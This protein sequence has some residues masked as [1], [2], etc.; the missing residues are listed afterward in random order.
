MGTASQHGPP[1]PYESVIMSDADV[2]LRSGAP[3]DPPPPRFEITVSDP[4][5]QGEGVNAF[6][7]YR[8]RTK[9]TMPHYHSTTL[10]VIR[11]Y[12][13][14]AFL[15]QRLFEQNRG[16]II[17]PIPEKNVVQK[18]QHTAGF[19]AKRRAALEK[20]I[21]RVGSHPAL[22]ESDDLRAF[23]EDNDGAWQIVLARANA[24]HGGGA[25]KTLAGAVAMMRELGSS[26]LALIG[27]S[28][29]RGED[30]EESPDYLK[31]REYIYQLE[32]H[33]SDVQKQASRLIRKQEALAA[34]LHDFGS[35]MIALSKFETGSLAAGFKTMGDKTESLVRDA[36]EHN[37]TLT[38]TL[39]APLK[40][41]VR[42]VQSAK[43]TMADRGAA[44]AAAQAA[45]GDVAHKRS[46]LTKLRGTP[47][48]RE[49]KVADMEHELNEAQR[50]VE[51]T[52]ATFDQ[53]VARM[54]TDFARFQAERADEMAMVLRAF[55]SAQAAAAARAAEA[56]QSLLPPDV[57]A[58]GSGGAS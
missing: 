56:W 53:I 41:F 49:N 1:P 39:D 38:Q 42:L 7:Q 32:A 51:V 48:I 12:S 29:T 13:D 30:S 6:M 4:I 27:A 35:S 11:R 47:G 15:H 55:A 46:K 44:L 31:V 9:T 16:I 14:F 45:R 25:K 19:L 50:R 5:K 28:S 3:Q 20:F 57:G 24:E 23:L 54:A 33:L 2:S 10:D 34:T 37:Y 40:E 21:N 58:D 17:P 18:Y 22:A 8:V 36:H 43:A 26:G 52:Q